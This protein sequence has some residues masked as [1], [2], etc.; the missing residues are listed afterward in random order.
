MKTG[1]TV[2]R[3]VVSFVDLY[4]KKE[5]RGKFVAVLPYSSKIIASGTS[6]RAVL[7]EAR[8]KGKED[9]VITRIPTEALAQCL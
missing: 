4:R 9:A 6:P 3:A 1:R 5:Y 7:E 2:E 8:A